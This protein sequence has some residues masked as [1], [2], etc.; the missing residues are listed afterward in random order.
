V[1]PINIDELLL[2]MQSS[3]TTTEQHRNHGLEKTSGQE[4]GAGGEVMFF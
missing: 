4:E 1:S 2:A 3:Y